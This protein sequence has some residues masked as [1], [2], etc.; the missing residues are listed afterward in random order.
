M[1]HCSARGLHPQ[2]QGLFLVRQ[3]CSG[4]SSPML[5]T[6]AARLRLQ[7]FRSAAPTSTNAPASSHERPAAS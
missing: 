4:C 3:K 5:L 7:P 6:F 1:Q 2:G